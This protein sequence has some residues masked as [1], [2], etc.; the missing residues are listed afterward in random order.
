MFFFL[1]MSE[2]RCLPNCCCY[3]LVWPNVGPSCKGFLKF[4]DDEDILR[5]VNF[6]GMGLL[7]PYELYCCINGLIVKCA[8]AG[9]IGARY[10]LAKVIM[11]TTSHMW[12]SYKT[13]KAIKRHPSLY[14]SIYQASSGQPPESSFLAHF[15][16][17]QGSS[18]N[19][20]G[21]RL[22]HSELVRLFLCRCSPIDLFIMR[23][24]LENY[25]K[26]FVRSRGLHYL[27]FLAKINAMAEIFQD[28]L[29]RSKMREVW[30]LFENTRPTSLCFDMRRRLSQS[31]FKPGRFT[32]ESAE[33][34][35]ISLSA[36]KI[37]ELERECGG[38]TTQL[39]PGMQRCIHIPVLNMVE[40]LNLNPVEHCLSYRELLE[41]ADPSSYLD[42]EKVRTRFEGLGNIFEMHRRKAM[43]TFNLIFP[44]DQEISMLTNPI[45][46]ISSNE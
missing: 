24:Y 46:Y 13:A 34:K 41:K 28:L 44:Q 29:Y 33:V 4:G 27:K 8:E 20:S 38:V 32:F 45:P 10:M 9:N 21:V 19:G 42:L 23:P 14:S 39:V 36:S 43:S 17:N 15:V 22:I 7:H 5:A 2:R 25:L 1:C 11:V 18:S 30:P 37:E 3:F 35:M 12:I 40:S 26:F 6:D 31:L 16:A